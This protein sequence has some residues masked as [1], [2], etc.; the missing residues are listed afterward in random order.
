MNHWKRIIQDRKTGNDTRNIPSEVGLHEV[1]AKCGHEVWPDSCWDWFFLLHR[2]RQAF[3]SDAEE[4]EEEDQR[5]GNGSVRFGSVRFGLRGDSE[6]PALRISNL[7]T[8]LQIW[9]MLYD[10]WFCLLSHYQAASTKPSFLLYVSSMWVLMYIYMSGFITKPTFL[11]LPSITISMKF[12]N[13]FD[14]KAWKFNLMPKHEASWSGP[15]VAMK[16]SPRLGPS[17]RCRNVWIQDHHSN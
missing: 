7:G 16:A 15:R 12:N 1:K 5:T 10:I 2:L 8:N 14:A 3:R 17:S 11:A 13:Q 4:E 9:G 6:S